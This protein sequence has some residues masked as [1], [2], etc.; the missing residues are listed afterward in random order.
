VDFVVGGLQGRPLMIDRATD[1]TEA[2][3]Q[4]ADILAGS[5][6]KA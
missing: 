4:I 1:R 2:I 5:F 6:Q 3:H